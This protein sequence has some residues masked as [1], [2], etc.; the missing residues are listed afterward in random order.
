[1]GH[2]HLL[3]AFL[4]M[5]AAERGAAPR[6]LSAYARDITALM[7]HLAAG[8]GDPLTADREALRAYLADLHGQGLRPATVARKL[9]AARQFFLFLFSEGWRSDNPA[10]RLD[11]PRQPRSLPDGLSE[12]D[13]D[14]LL[15]TAKAEAET[16]GS[17]AA[18]R[19]HALMELLYATGLRVSE[20]VGL[21]RKAWHPDKPILFVTGKGGKDRQVPV[22]DPAR[23]AVKAYL[24]V[25]DRAS[26]FLFPSRGAS[27]HLTRRRVGQ[28][29]T[30]LAVRAGVDPEGVSPHSLRHAFATHLLAGGA[31]LRSLQSLLGHAAI[32]TTQI[33][34]HVLDARLRELV[35][36]HHP[37]AGSDTTE[38]D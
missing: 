13:V 18:L 14:R 17:V 38:G 15:D 16:D 24:D 20:A 26:P 10:A 33:Y 5:M 8:G 12:Q 19:L 23:R 4:E 25:S 7:D 3:D 11:G 6:S 37:L 35:Q 21:P 31:D 29:V 36:Q 27:G 34:T 9:S 1:M 28:L 22:A 32:S 2:D 30:E